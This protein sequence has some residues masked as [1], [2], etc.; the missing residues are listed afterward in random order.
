MIGKSTIL[1]GVLAFSAAVP[2]WAQSQLVVS[3]GPKDSVAWIAAGDLNEVGRSCGTDIDVALSAGAIT[4]LE[5]MQGPVAANAAILQGDVLDYL[6]SY[7]GQDPKI[8]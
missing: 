4:S 5:A 6:Q 1:A 8:A 7:R 3:A 2:G